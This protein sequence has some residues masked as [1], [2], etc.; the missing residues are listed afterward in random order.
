MNEKL[1]ELNTQISVLMEERKRVMEP[2]ATGRE[3]VGFESATSVLA[4]LSDIYQIQIS[5]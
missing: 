4:N 5:S 2:P 1:I 3:V